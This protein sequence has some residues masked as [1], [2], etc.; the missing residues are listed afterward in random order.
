MAFYN[1][2]KSNASKEADRAYAMMNKTVK[3]GR[4]AGNVSYSVGVAAK[5]AFLD[6]NPTIKEINNITGSG[7]KNVRAKYLERMEARNIDRANKG[8]QKTSKLSLKELA[9]AASDAYKESQ[10][11]DSLDVD[12]LKS[13]GIT[14]PC[15]L[16]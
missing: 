8:L 4:Y 9:L 16:F 15:V 3:I 6:L 7:I 14:L 5:D 10:K 11:G 13:E 2:K 12:E 1:R